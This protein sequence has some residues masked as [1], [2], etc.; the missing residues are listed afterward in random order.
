MASYFLCVFDLF[1]YFQRILQY[2][3]KFDYDYFDYVVV[4]FL[5]VYDF[6]GWNPQYDV[7]RLELEIATEKEDCGRKK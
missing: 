2:V 7:G 5:Y 6:A 4:V 3:R 1:G